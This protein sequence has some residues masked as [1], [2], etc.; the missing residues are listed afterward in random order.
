M[1]GGPKSLIFFSRACGSALVSSH[2]AT[3]AEMAEQR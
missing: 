3:G 2:F 1:I